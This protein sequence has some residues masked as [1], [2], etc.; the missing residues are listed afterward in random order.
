MGAAMIALFRYKL[1]VVSVIVLSAL[2]G[3]LSGFI[4]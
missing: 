2:V 4:T 3:V 1:G